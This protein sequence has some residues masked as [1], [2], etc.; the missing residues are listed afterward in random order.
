MTVPAKM[1]A[2]LLTG[3]GGY[4]KLELRRDVP[5]PVPEANEV[6]IRVG[7]CGVNNTDINTRKGWYAP[8]VR[9][10]TDGSVAVTESDQGGAWSGQLAF[11]RIQ[12]ADVV[13][14]IVAVGR[15]VPADR[16]GQRVLVEPV[17]RDPKAPHERRRI[18][19]LGSE[20]DGGFAEYVAVPSVSAFSVDSEL[21]DAAL[22]TFPCSYSTAEHMLSRIRLRQQD[23]V[24][25]T[26]ASGGVGSA[27]VQLAK[28]RGAVVIA[29]AS[30]PKQAA[31]AALGADAVIDRHADLSTSIHRL[32]YRDGV[33]VVADVVGGDGFPDLIGALKGGGRYVTAGAI[34]GP[35]VSLDLRQ[36]Y[37]KDLE[38]QGATVLPLGLFGQLVGYIER[39][40]IRPLLA[41]QYPL[42]DIR[43]AQEAFM[44]KAHVG[45]IVLLP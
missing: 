35:M 44:A 16:I 24:L 5:V 41:A 13:G 21:S 40:E 14:R 3:Y 22:A 33:D 6:L 7:A 1:T 43:K 9:G 10:A 20:R 8:S 23:T 25:I 45:N 32:G 31:V 28:R 19:Y 38:F 18:E 11:P 37:L 15:R 29:V 12:G 26:G 39:E 36:L 30:A 34:A 27:L 4:D 42:V 17:V 2:V